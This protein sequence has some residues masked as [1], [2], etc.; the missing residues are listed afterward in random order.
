MFENFHPGFLFFFVG[1][2]AAFSDAKPR[3]LILAAGPLL[4][5]FSMCRLSLGTDLA[6]S[7]LPDFTL[8]YLLVDPL[9]FIFGVTFCILGAIGGIYSCHNKSPMEAFCSMAYVGSSIGVVLAHDWITF[10][11]FWEL[12]A[13]TSTFLIW[14]DPR[15]ESKSAGIRYILI[16]TLSGNLVLFG[17]LL[18]LMAGDLLV[19]NLVGGP[20]DLAFWLLLSG[21]LI[22]AAAVP[23]HGWLVDG[24]PAA[25]LTGS[26]FMSS[27][28]TKVAVY[29]LLRV[30]GGTDLLI[31]VGVLMALY[32]ATFAVMEN[33]M[34]RLLSYH[35][36][37]Q[38]G[39]MVAGVGI[40]T[41]MSMNGAAAHA[42]C[43]I[44]YKSLLFM[45]CSALIYA[46]GV[47]RIN[48]L[49][50][51]A[52]RYPLVAVCFAV[53]AFSI[54][55]VPLFNGF[56]SKMITITAAEAAHLEA[57]ALLLELASMGTLLS[58]CFKMLYFIFL[59]PDLGKA[60]EVRPVEANM[61]IA[62]ALG[63]SLCVVI[64]LFPERTLYPFLPFG[65]VGYVPFTVGHVTNQLIMMTI[66]LIPFLLFLPRMEPHTAISLD[67]DWFYRRPLKRVFG[68]IT[69]LCFALCRGLGSA[70]GIG[71]HQIMLVCDNPMQFLDAKPFREKKHYSPDNYRTSI[72][73]T[74]MIIL[75]VLFICIFYF[76]TSL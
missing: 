44:L 24:Y 42:V 60:A 72:A 48:E 21:F 58:I 73:D 10:L 47:R 30:F 18:K 11:C 76:R 45:C 34:I 55:G 12:E 65:A 52:R 67:F 22:N 20:H 36:V 23:L 41:L 16:H 53:G 57:A 26:V 54:A 69:Y 61:K 32:G 50:G 38:V 63:A 17:V 37:S 51:M 71:V 49:G 39:Y 1:L 66:G 3:R 5:V 64:G 59:R 2:F 68:G 33:D 40:G 46:T 13:V 62:M 29:A 15:P 56:V 43:H 4:A 14:N 27:C 7:F 31:G 70:W 9:S 25:T 35:I 28:T 74:I 6:F 19:H 8:R 75:T